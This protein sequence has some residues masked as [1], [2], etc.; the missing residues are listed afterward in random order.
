MQTVLEYSYNRVLKH[1]RALRHQHLRLKI[2]VMSRANQE[3]VG[4]LATL[5]DF[6]IKFSD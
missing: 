4:I 3:P 6:K 1:I 5:N 2:F